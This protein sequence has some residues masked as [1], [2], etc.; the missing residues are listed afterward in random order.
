MQV[1]VSHN[2]ILEYYLGSLGFGFLKS[3]SGSILKGC[4]FE[5]KDLNVI[6]QLWMESWKPPETTEYFYNRGQ[7]ENE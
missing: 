5:I 2:Y 6:L 4:E 7:I 3:L 1:L